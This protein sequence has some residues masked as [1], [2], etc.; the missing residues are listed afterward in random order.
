MQHATQDGWEPLVP[1]VERKGRGLQTLR[2]AQEVN[3]HHLA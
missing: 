3:D 2:H 1:L